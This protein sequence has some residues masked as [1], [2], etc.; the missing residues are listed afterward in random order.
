M[1]RSGTDLIFK[2]GAGTDQITVKNW[3]ADSTGYCQIEHIN[4][5]DGTTWTNAQ[6]H[7]DGH[8]VQIV[9]SQALA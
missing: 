3:F 9:G 6:I 8:A 2:V 7:T 5:A 1:V 4:F